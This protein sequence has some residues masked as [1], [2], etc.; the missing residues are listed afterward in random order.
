MKTKFIPIFFFIG[1]LSLVF[2]VSC[3]KE[4]QQF[5]I[6]GEI[7]GNTNKTLYLENIGTAKIK[8]LDSV[9]IE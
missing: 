6:S 5:N 3:K 7:M 1:I 2:F 9:K 8:V 4:K